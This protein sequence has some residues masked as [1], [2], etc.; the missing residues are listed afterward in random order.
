MSCNTCHCAENNALYCTKMACLNDESIHLL[1]HFKNSPLKTLRQGSEDN[2][3]YLPELPRVT[4]VSTPNDVSPPIT[5]DDYSGLPRLPH[6]AAKCERGKIYMVDCNSCLCLNSGNLICESKLCPVEED[7]M[8]SG[9][10]VKKLHGPSKKR[11]ILDVYKDK[12]EPGTMYNSS[13]IRTKP[14]A[15]G[16]HNLTVC[17]ESFL[18][19]A[20]YLMSGHEYIRRIGNDSNAR[21]SSVLNKVNPMIEEI[22]DKDR[23][24]L[25]SARNMVGV[26]NSD[27][28]YDSKSKI[29][30]RTQMPYEEFDNEAI[31]DET[32]KQ[33]SSNLS[34]K[35]NSDDENSQIHVKPSISLPGQ[36]VAKRDKF[37]SKTNTLIEKTNN[38]EAVQSEKSS[39]FG[40]NLSRVAKKVWSEH[41]TKNSH[42]L[43]DCNWCWC[44]SNHRYKCH[45]RACGEVDMFGHFNDAI[46]DIDVGIE[47][48]GSWR[49]TETACSP[50][51]HYRRDSVLCVCNEDGNWPN[52]VCRDIFRVMHSVE[53]TRGIEISQK[54]EPSKLHLVGC[55][56]CFCPS[57]GILNLDLCTKMTCLKEDPVMNATRNLEY[58]MKVEDDSELE[59]YAT[60]TTNKQYSLECRTCT[61][62]RNNRLLCNSNN[63]STVERRE[64]KSNHPNL[65]K[66]SVCDNYDVGEIFNE[67]CNYCFCDGK[68][69]KY[70]T[71]KRCLKYFPLRQ[72]DITENEF[73]L[74]Q[75]PI[76][77]NECKP[78]TKYNRD[79]NTCYCSSQ[80]GKK[81]FSCTMKQCNVKNA[82]DLI[83][84]D[85]VNRT[86]Y[87]KNCLIC[88]CDIEAGAK[89]ETCVADRSCT[90]ISYDKET[91]ALD[92]ELLQGFCK[93]LHGYKKEC[94]TCQC[95]SNSKI[96]KCTSRNCKSPQALTVEVIPVKPK[97]P[98]H[99]PIGLSYELDCN[100]CF[101]LEN[102]NAI[103][104]TNDC[105]DKYE[106][107][108]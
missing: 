22:Y 77:N 100:V 46:K 64:E 92:I 12:C 32:D 17:G 98:D 52:P 99:C 2:G 30:S 27:S 76:D 56:V 91:H 41:C 63:C 42:V 71:T 24:V 5:D 55:N 72:L 106:D 93:P 73:E 74:T 107:L 44:D 21:P 4:D 53:V 8:W 67:A 45:A 88:R 81:S 75:A 59:I 16:M 79:C 31:S 13:N 97:R 1:K 96:L 33:E 65:I 10:K 7:K 80:N 38:I 61:C 86:M 78:G 95:L 105:E 66:E 104:T 68:S 29:D 54:C 82:V 69:L 26:E 49:T 89:R 102:G 83:E 47:G 90:R 51:V 18:K 57:S 11:P 39:H 101:C 85:C 40:V 48:K 34:S 103:C 94:N 23:G 20:M 3:P 36:L 70:C 84:N 58:E 25:I 60:C 108:Y 6:S 50:G 15:L 87:E 35:N 19:D 62:L 37:P 43:N 14:L 28:E 9:S